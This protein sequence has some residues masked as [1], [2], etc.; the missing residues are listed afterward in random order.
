MADYLILIKMAVYNEQLKLH[1]EGT[2]QNRDQLKLLEV[3][4]SDMAASSM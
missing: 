4:A 2:V 3:E 1:I